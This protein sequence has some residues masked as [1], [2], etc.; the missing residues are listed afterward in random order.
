M[1]QGGH[2]GKSSMWLEC[3][4]IKEGKVGK[5]GWSLG[6]E[7]LRTPGWEFSRTMSLTICAQD[8]HH[9]SC[10]KESCCQ[11]GETLDKTHRFL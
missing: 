4:K 3:R 1:K 8:A 5:Q 9:F 11:P 6:C 7:G 10:N 2:K